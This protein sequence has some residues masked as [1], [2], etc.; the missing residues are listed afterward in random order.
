MTQV[1]EEQNRLITFTQEGQHYDS[2]FEYMP[3]S[4]VIAGQKGWKLLDRYSKAE[5]RIS[6]L[7]LKKTVRINHRRHAK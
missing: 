1:N 4:Y 2:G 3:S 7:S 6:P 5:G